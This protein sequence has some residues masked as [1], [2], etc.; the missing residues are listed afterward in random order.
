MILNN[1]PDISDVSLCVNDT[2]ISLKT[3]VKLLSVFTD[4]DLNFS[5]LVTYLYNCWR[6]TA[7]WNCFMLLK[8]PIFSYCAT[9]W[10]FYSKSSTIKMEKGQKATRRVAYND[11]TADY[12]QLLSMSKRFPQIIV[13]LSALLIE[14]RKL[15]PL[16]WI[17]CLLWTIS[18]AIYAESR[19]SVGLK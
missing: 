13:W 8:Y 15:N 17:C 16:L 3:S 10:H 19:G 9:M 4:Y 5:D 14:I 7:L 12:N 18:P 2:N 11:Y 6:K 1:H